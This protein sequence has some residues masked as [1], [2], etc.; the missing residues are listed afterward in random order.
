V[1][2]TN[3][4]DLSHQLVQYRRFTPPSTFGTAV[5]I[6]S[7][8]RLEPSLSQDGSGGVYAT[9][10][11]NGGGVNLAYSSSHG[12]SWDGPVTIE[13]NSGGATHI[14]GLASARSWASPRTR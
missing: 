9:W 8:A 3:V 5:T 1:L 7:S 6:A 13:S 10:L 4:K 14:G 11:D 2:E 12:A